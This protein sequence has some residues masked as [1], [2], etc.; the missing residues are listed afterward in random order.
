VLIPMIGTDAGYCV[1]G[2]LLTATRR[3]KLLERLPRIDWLKEL[4]VFGKR[5]TYVLA[6]ID[7][8]AAAMAHSC[9]SFYRSALL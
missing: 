7:R 9:D 3:V 4:P 6:L 5:L 8:N 2:R 1:R